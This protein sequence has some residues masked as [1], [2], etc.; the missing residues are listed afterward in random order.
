MKS[1]QKFSFDPLPKGFVTNKPLDQEAYNESIIYELERENKLLISRK[2]NGWK[3][4]IVSHGDKIKIY[5][6]GLHRVEYRLPPLVE[7]YEKLRLPSSTLLVAEA[8]IEKNG[9]DQLG[10]IQSVLNVKSDPKKSIESQEKLGFAKTMIFGALFFNNKD[11]SV[12]PYS[13]QYDVI[14]NTNDRNINL[15]YIFP[16]EMLDCSYDKAKEMVLEKEWEGL[17]LYDKDYRFAYSVRGSKRP[18]RPKGCYKKKPETE[19][20]FIVREIIFSDIHKKRVKEVVLN[21]IDPVTGEEFQCGKF[22]KFTDLVR[23]NLK[24]EEA[25]LPLVMQVT[26]ESRFPSGKLVNAK[27]FVRLRYDKRSEECLAPKSYK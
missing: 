6:V 22:G 24:R 12:L 11:L 16:I 15:K 21:Q 10:L 20:D 5:T 1:P 7:E 23:E 25:D 13:N 4:Y 3:L 18:Q 19:G 26:Y 8:H 2:R 17:V 14:K 9:I 27:K